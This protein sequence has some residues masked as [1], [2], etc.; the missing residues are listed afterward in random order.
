MTKC[1][2]TENATITTGPHGFQG[3]YGGGLVFTVQLF[4]F[5]IRSQQIRHLEW[6][7]NHMIR[8]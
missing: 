5:L 8:L 7:W 3:G 1:T 2:I 4:W 6:W